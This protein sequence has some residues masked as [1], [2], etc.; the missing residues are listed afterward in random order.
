MLAFQ[1][2]SSHFALRSMHRQ[3]S[4]KETPLAVAWF[5]P[6]G[7]VGAGIMGHGIAAT[8]A[9]NGFEVTLCDVSQ[10]M[11]DKALVNIEES[12][13]KI[14][15]FQ[16]KRGKMK[17]A[18]A[19][20]TLKDG[21]ARIKTTTKLEDL[22]HCDLVVESISENPAI[23]KSVYEQLGQ[24]LHPGAVVGSNTSSFSVTELGKF[25]GRPSQVC[26]IHFFNP[27][28]VMQLVEVI[29]TVDT[30][31]RTFNAGLAF[32]KCLG[33]VSVKCKDTPGFIVNRLLVPYLTQACLMADRGDAT[34][35]DIDQAMRLGAGMPTGPLQLADFV[36]L[37]TC[38]AILEGWMQKMPDEG[39]FQMPENLK[40]R[41]AAGKFG[42]KTGEGFYR[43]DGDKIVE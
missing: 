14:F 15:G 12:G 27:V 7:V 22:K 10:E 30:S 6:V 19:E 26:G 4:T 2:A 32:A 21:L 29:K 1:R 41:V 3:Y 5:T 16:V 9:I 42:R 8:A 28:L 11:L 37:D 13:K 40:E 35:K 36:G 24:I 34:L 20:R 23:K 39:I 17:P 38:H 31:D 18:A 33:K 25:Y 43:W